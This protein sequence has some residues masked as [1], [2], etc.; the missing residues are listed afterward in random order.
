MLLREGCLHHFG[1]E[2]ENGGLPVPKSCPAICRESRPCFCF[3]SC[4]SMTRENIIISPRPLQTNRRIWTVRVS[5][6][7]GRTIM[8]CKSAAVTCY[9]LFVHTLSNEAGAGQFMTDTCSCLR[10][11]L[12][13]HPCHCPSLCVLKWNR[14]NNYLPLPA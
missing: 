11:G 9:S 8:L 6:I 2:H 10:L 5:K 13:C 14:C 12:K 4:I 1:S 3:C 7:S